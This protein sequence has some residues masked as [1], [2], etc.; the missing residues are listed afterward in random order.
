MGHPLSCNVMS[1]LTPES[2]TKSTMAPS[3]LH[4][5][6]RC[7][8]IAVVF[9]T[10]LWPCYSHG[11]QSGNH[12]ANQ[13]IVITGTWYHTII[14]TI[15][16]GGV[17]YIGIADGRVWVYTYT[18]GTHLVSSRKSRGDPTENPTKHPGGTWRLSGPQ[19]PS[20]RH[21][22]LLSQP[23]TTSKNTGEAI[24]TQVLVTSPPRPPPERVN[25]RTYV[26]WGKSRLWLRTW[27][28]R[29]HVYKRL[30]LCRGRFQYNNVLC[31]T[32]A[33]QWDDPCSLIERQMR[34]QP[35]LPVPGN[36][37]IRKVL[38]CLRKICIANALR[39]APCL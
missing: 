4:C 36:M 27:Y 23:C 21:Q 35:V 8:Y 18:H 28:E 19:G 3:M 37:K 29:D 24:R 14:I 22:P 7:I 5:L 32:A 12:Y 20:V 15:S 13:C 1:S 16:M 30:M 2:A 9:A 6:I 33:A 17:V 11:R 39:L 34:T 31:S 38:W 25:V 26:P 10:V